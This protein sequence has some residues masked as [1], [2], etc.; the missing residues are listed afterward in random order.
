MSFMKI[1]LVKT[2]FYL[3]VYWIFDPLFPHFSYNLSEIRYK[4]CTI[5]FEDSRVS[6]TSAQGRP[7]FSYGRKLNCLYACI[8]KPY[9]IFKVKNTL[10]KSLVYL[11]EHTIFRVLT[12]ELVFFL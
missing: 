4:R 12:T 9:D 1:C 3:R 7:Y 10:V 8:V 5:D 11:T 6:R 2:I